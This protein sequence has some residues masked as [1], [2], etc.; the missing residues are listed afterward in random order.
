MGGTVVKVTANARGATLVELRKAAVAVASDLADGADH[1]VKLGDVYASTWDDAT[2]TD[3]GRVTGLH[4]SV[5]IT[6]TEATA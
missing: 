4:A 5:E 1:T 3:T 2:S 6:I